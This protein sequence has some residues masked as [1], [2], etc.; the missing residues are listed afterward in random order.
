M[1]TVG[2][3]SDFFRNDLL[4]GAESN[5]DNLIN[6]LSQFYNVHSI[7]SNLFSLKDVEECDAIIV[8]NFLLLQ[9]NVIEAIIKSKKYIIYEHDHKY[10]STRDPSKFLNF[11][12]PKKHLVNEKFYNSAKTIVV[13]T[14]ICKEIINANIPNVQVHSIGCSLWNDK[15]FD[16]L[17]SLSQK[18]K[19]KELCVMKSDNLTKNYLNTLSFCRQ[20]SLSP[21]SIESSNYHDFLNLMSQYQKFLFIPTVLE[22]FSRIC[23]EAKMMNVSVMTNK[24]LIGLFSED[25]SSQ[26]GSELINTLRQKNAAAYDFFRT[27]IQEICG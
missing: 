27:E 19:N 23:A 17:E 11:V 24:R 20:N 16:L 5:D 13:L 3:V 2:F 25:Y 14:E 1:K 7:K 12:I 15:T 4:G 8:S 22:T 10:V 26:N 21:D 18:Q 6:Y 9:Q